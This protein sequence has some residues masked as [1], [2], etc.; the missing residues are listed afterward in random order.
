MALYAEGI[1]ALMQERAAGNHSGKSKR[2][3]A[4][5]ALIIAV[6]LIASAS[7]WLRTL[8]P[9]LMSK[10]TLIGTFPEDLD[11]V[12]CEYA[13]LSGSST[14]LIERRTTYTISIASDY[15]RR[16]EPAGKL[17][18]IVNDYPD[19]ARFPFVSP[20]NKWIGWYSDGDILVTS[21]DGE[22]HFTVPQNDRAPYTWSADSTA[23]LQTY[24]H[25]KSNIL[26]R[27]VSTAVA[28]QHQKTIVK[29]S[30]GHRESN[31][32]G[33]VIWDGKTALYVQCVGPELQVDTASLSSKTPDKR[34][35]TVAV[36]G[37]LEVS[38]PVPSPDAKK[39]ALI[40]V[41]KS[42]PGVFRWLSK[43]SPWLHQGSPVFVSLWTV[44]M[45]GT[46]LK[47]VGRAYGANELDLDSTDLVTDLRWSPDGKYIGFRHLSHVY[48]VPG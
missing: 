35:L 10:A 26:D 5:W 23:V 12:D 3:A 28:P 9:N 31:S 20:D 44:N 17:T 11:S 46:H 37:C 29:T 16:M 15:G 39:L 1:S 43:I 13:L 8:P 6:V 22:R 7:S 42:K 21:T 34:L 40:A 33:D 4:C 47:E 32:R 14:L 48:T 38:Q 2:R 27:I 18:A 25:R 41:G 30:P 45:D 36:P 19:G 24:C